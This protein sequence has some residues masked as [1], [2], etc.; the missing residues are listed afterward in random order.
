MVVYS[1]R[2]KDFVLRTSKIMKAETF[3]R[4]SSAPLPVPFRLFNACGDKLDDEQDFD[5]I[6]EGFAALRHLGKP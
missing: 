5:A 3:S 6:E 4:K 2:C 1:C